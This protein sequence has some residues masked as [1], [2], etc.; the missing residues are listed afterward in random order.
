MKLHQILS[1]LDR[2]QVFL[3]IIWCRLASEVTFPDTN[4]LKKFNNK[5]QFYSII[6]KKNYLAPIQRLKMDD[7]IGLEPVNI[8]LLSKKKLA[9]M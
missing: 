8:L 7:Y 1:V 6:G 2:Q 9:E 3:W 5:R 4:T